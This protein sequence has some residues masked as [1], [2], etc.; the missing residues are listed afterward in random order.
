MVYAEVAPAAGWSARLEAKLW[1]DLRIERTVF[2]ART[3]ARPVAFREIQTFDPRDLLS[4]R[5]RWGL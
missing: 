1:D 3:L 2:E 4:V 5:V